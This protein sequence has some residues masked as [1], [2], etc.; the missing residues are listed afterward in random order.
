MLSICI[1]HFNFINQNLLVTLF[2]QCKQAGINFEILIADDAS[3]PENKGYLKA[4]TEA[5]FRLFFLEE[6]IGRAAI[7]NFLAQQAKFKYLLFLDADAEIIHDGFISNYMHQLKDEEIVCGGRV[8]AKEISRPDYFLH[9]KY[10]SKVE[11]YAQAQFQTNNFLIP[12]AFFSALS[13]DERIKSYGYEDVLF[14]LQAKKLGFSIKQIDNP[15]KHIQLKTNQEFVDDLEHALENLNKLIKAGICDD[16][17]SEVS[18]AS[19][20]Q[21]L[22]KYRLNFFLSIGH[23]AVQKK[24]RAILFLNIP[25]GTISLI[26]LYKLYYYHSLQN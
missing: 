23:D 12:K 13:F 8:Y 18:V 5:E 26:A 9:H 6:N 25:I 21:K 17:T 2:S 4:F 10:G 15:V 24:L 11:Q 19:F 20:Y 22:K 1:P 3:K 16:L 14:G 7:R